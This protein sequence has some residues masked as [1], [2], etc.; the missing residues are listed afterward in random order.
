MSQH[1]ETWPSLAEGLYDRL[2]ARNAEITY[3]FDDMSVKVPSGTGDKVAHA[4]WLLNGTL[5]ITTRDQDS[6]PNS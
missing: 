2:T 4:E 3:T 6:V 5:R 1:T